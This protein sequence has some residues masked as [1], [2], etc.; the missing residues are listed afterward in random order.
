MIY[1]NTNAK[2]L[3]FFLR[4]ENKKPKKQE[5]CFKLP[6]KLIQPNKMEKIDKGSIAP[7]IVHIELF[8][9]LRNL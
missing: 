3:E 8:I 7:Y 6:K 4:T 2:S 1:R 9:N 5:I